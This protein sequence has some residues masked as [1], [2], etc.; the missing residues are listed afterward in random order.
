MRNAG[1]SDSDGEKRLSRRAANATAERGFSQ[2]KKKR[3]EETPANTFFP[4]SG[5]GMTWAHRP[6]R[7]KR[8]NPPRLGWCRL[9]PAALGAGL[10]LLGYFL[11]VLY[12]LI[13]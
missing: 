11:I 2:W 13:L 1:S 10:L 7:A 4:T 6:E 3:D 5:S 12:F 8:L 9:L